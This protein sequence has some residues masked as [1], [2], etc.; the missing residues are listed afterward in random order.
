MSGYVEDPRQCE[1]IQDELAE[2][3]LGTLFGRRRSEVLDHVESCSR[4]AAT[5]EQLSIVADQL[6]Q[7]APEIEP[8]L[9][10]ELRLA[11]KLRSAAPVR[12]PSRFRRTGLLSAAAAVI[13]ALGIGIGTLANP[14]GGGTKPVVRST[15]NLTAARLTSHGHV[16]GEV[17]I[18]AG[19]PAWM[20][21]TINEGGWSGS[22][23]CEVTL[24][25]GKVETIGEFNLSGGYGAWGAPLTSAAGKVRS[26]RL[27]APDGAI[28]ASAR[29][30]A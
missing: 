29:L 11:E 15:V 12:Q 26:A 21:V 5:L 20:F 16:L 2:L 19:S 24:A 27:I 18:S 14:F 30:T 1:A 23:K 13:V 6:V 3:A 9:G 22:V 7:L 8:P 17:M 28:L 4:C 25:G 10:F